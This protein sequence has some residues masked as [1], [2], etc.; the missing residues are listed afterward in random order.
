MIRISY[1]TNGPSWHASPVDGG[2]PLLFGTPVVQ[3][4][5]GGILVPGKR[6]HER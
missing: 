4:R 6:L 5:G 3:H 1:L 2:S